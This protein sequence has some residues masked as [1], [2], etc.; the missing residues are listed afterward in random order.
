MLIKSKALKGY[1][2]QG[3]DGEIG[4]VE[5]FYFDD[6]HWTVRYLIANTGGWLIGHQVLISPYSLLSVN[7]EE[8]TISI[9][10]T[11]IKIEE[12]PPLGSD[13]PVS[14]Q[15][16]EQYYQYY[17]QPM[18]WGGSYMWGASP[19]IQNDIYM[20]SFENA[21]SPKSDSPE[22]EN[23]KSESMKSEAM[24]KEE[25][26]MAKKESWDPNLRST[27][28]VRGYAIRGIDGDIGH[29]DDFVIDDEN[30]AI[31]YIVI[32][33]KNFWPAKKVLVS[34]KW[35]ERID[36]IHSIAY[37]NVSCDTIMKS[38][39]YTDEYL[40]DR[41]YETDLHQFFNRRGYWVDELEHTDNEN[42]SKEE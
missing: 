29:I 18:Y 39:E 32:D 23:L 28:T 8:R 33:T 24:K 21:E 9:N 25:E 1:K 20:S 41:G 10:L 27:D 13:K 3:L 37:V 14:M 42:F 31:R 36:W 6:H 26:K 11:K 34:P 19:H 4:K 40:L 5:D 38:P 12:S 2:L 7:D 17:G 22:S 16:Q 15:Y 35:I 30:W